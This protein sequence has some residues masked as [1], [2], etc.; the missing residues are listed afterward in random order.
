MAALQYTDHILQANYVLPTTKNM[1]LTTISQNGNSDIHTNVR[2]VTT[3]T[4]ELSPHQ[5]QSC[6]HTNGRVVSWITKYKQYK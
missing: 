2:V 1:G 3:L 6:H 5:R 4:A